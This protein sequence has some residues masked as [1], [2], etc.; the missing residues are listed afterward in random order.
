[1]RS[2]SFRLLVALL[3]AS[4]EA[5]D[6]RRSRAG[7]KLV[8]QQ[9]QQQQQQ[10][11]APQQPKHA[12]NA[13]VA[14][15]APSCAGK[16]PRRESVATQ[17]MHLELYAAMVDQ[18]GPVKAALA[19]LLLVLLV[20]AM[21]TLLSAELLVTLFYIVLYFIASPFAIMVNKILMKDYGFGYP[22]MVS[23]LGQTTTA[24]C[25]S[26]V[27]RCFGLSIENG[28]RVG[29]RS[30]LMLGGAS[31]FALVLG[32]YPYLYL[33]VAFIQMLKAFSPTRRSV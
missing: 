29:C 21:R 22:V 6:G 9:Q 11:K 10:G 20:M 19:L 16:C 27:V 24:V 31:A 32:Q 25:S 7:G 8:E 3:L 17:H 30:L 28:R 14:L 4:A 18:V 5:A 12:G 15:R 33:T 1:M 2:H 26:A 13:T 23:A